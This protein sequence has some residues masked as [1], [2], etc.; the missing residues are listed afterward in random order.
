MSPTHKSRYMKQALH[1][2]INLVELLKPENPIE[3]DLIEQT[4]FKEGLLWGFPR[5]GHPEGKVAY[6][7]NE[8]LANVDKLNLND[9]DLRTKLRLIAFSH[10]S[11]KH[12]EDKSRNPRD[13]SKHHGA[14]ARQ[15]ISKYTD[16]PGILDIIQWHDEAYYVWRLQHIYRDH[17]ASTQRLNNLKDVIGSNI[18]LYYLFFVCDTRTGDKNQ[19]PL[20]WFERTFTGID[21]VK[22]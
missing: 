12:L 15:F 9:S 1:K 10:D 3:F 18:Q 16:D 6:H 11:F 4:E 8:V 5:F 14:I 22:I 21:L 7:I 20:K 2:N 19:A 13:W 17:E